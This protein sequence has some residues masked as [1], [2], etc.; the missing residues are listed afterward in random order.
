M[1]N[2]LQKINKN[3]SRVASQPSLY[4]TKLIFLVARLENTGDHRKT[5]VAPIS[6]LY[7]DALGTSTPKA[8]CDNNR[9]GWADRLALSAAYLIRDVCIP[10]RSRVEDERRQATVASMATL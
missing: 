7:G 1:I 8:N 10:R 6:L 9:R 5:N 3:Y 2:M 4:Q